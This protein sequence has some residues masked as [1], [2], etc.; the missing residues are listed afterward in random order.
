MKN[1]GFLF[2]IIQESLKLGEKKTVV[3]KLV[4]KVFWYRQGK[5]NNWMD[6][7]FWTGVLRPGSAGIVCLFDV[8]FVK[9]VR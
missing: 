1:G 7:F 9:K 6:T 5:L 4:D 2:L 3:E 8:K